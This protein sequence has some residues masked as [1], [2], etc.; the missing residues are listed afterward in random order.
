VRKSTLLWT[1]IIIL[2]LLN[3][4]T[5]FFLLS[6]R[7][8]G[9]PERRGGNK[10][11]DELVM[12]TLELT[13][14][15][16]DKFDQMKRQHHEQMLQLDEATKQPFDAYFSLLTQPITDSAT[17]DSLEKKITDLYR[18]RMQVTYRH[19]AE[20]KAICTPQQQQK[21]DALVPSLMQV[22][23]TGE[24]NMEHHRRKMEEPP[25]KQ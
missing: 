18:Q 16:V 25:Y 15:Q 23:S 20:L 7:H 4:G 3:A 2:F 22:M 17:R 12:H 8:H 13:P 24:K 6:S 9:P 11:F 14:G 19:F 21:F 10:N 1:A 5:L